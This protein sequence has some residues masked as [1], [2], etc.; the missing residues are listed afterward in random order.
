MGE[1]KMLFINLSVQCC[2]IHAEECF[3][4]HL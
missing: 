1:M 2:S 4:F 3:G